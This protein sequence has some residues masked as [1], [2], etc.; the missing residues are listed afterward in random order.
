MGM[1]VDAKLMYGY[2]MPEIPYPHPEWYDEEYGLDL[3][4]AWF[5]LNAPKDIKALDL[6]AEETDD[7]NSLPYD[8]NGNA[9]WDKR[10]PEE[11]AR[12]EEYSRRHGL[13]LD[14]QREWLKQNPVPVEL[15][16]V[17]SY[18]SEEKFLA[19][20]Y[21]GKP[22]V[23]STKWSATRVTEDDLKAPVSPEEAKAVLDEF[24][25]TL[26]LEPS[27]EP[28]GWYLAPLYSH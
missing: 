17:G 27:T 21:E 25:T 16:Y 10:T 22:V 3:E 6:T 18:D 20:K 7:W 8:G 11:K 12:G 15:E 14:A 13:F 4:R 24:C 28:V 19:V 26:G 2:P 9:A 23:H 1:S 5:I